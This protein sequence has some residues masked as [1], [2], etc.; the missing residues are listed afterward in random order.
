MLLHD[1]DQE[2]LVIIFTERGYVMYV[3]HK[4]DKHRYKWF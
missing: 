4:A 1:N 3:Y 2:A